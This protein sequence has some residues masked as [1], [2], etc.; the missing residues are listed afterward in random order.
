MLR[1]EGEESSAAKAGYTNE[2]VSQAVN[3][4][5][6]PFAL[7]HSSLF[8]KPMHRNEGSSVFVFSPSAGHFS[9]GQNYDF[10]G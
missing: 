10:D 4:V 5:E 7:N 3:C 8:Q 9:V 2:L 6:A 1:S